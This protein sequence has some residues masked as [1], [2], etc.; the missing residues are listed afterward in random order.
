MAHCSTS[1]WLQKDESITA[2]RSQGAID[3]SLVLNVWGPEGPAPIVTIG[4]SLLS[5]SE[6]REVGRQLRD[7]SIEVA[8]FADDKDRT[9]G[10][11]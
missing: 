4:L 7:A 8:R 1:I 3:D 5:V 10:G 11:K 6:I 9:E 2:S